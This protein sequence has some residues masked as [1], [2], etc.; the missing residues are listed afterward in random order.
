[1]LTWMERAARSAALDKFRGLGLILVAVCTLSANVATHGGALSPSEHSFH[2]DREMTKVYEGEVPLAKEALDDL[3][4][5]KFESAWEKA[6]SAAREY[7]G[8]WDRALSE[9]VKLKRA[10]EL[11]HR[12][13]DLER[14]ACSLKSRV[15]DHYKELGPRAHEDFEEWSF[16]WLQNSTHEWLHLEADKEFAEIYLWVCR[17]IGAETQASPSEWFPYADLVKELLPSGDEELGD[18]RAVGI[19]AIALDRARERERQ[20]RGDIERDKDIPDFV[21]DYLMALSGANTLHP[22]C[23]AYVRYNWP[24]YVAAA[25]SNWRSASNECVQIWPDL[26]KGLRHRQS[27][28]LQQE[29]SL[30]RGRPSPTPRNGSGTIACPRSLVSRSVSSTGWRMRSRWRRCCGRWRNWTSGVN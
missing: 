4:F 27:L 20:L 19:L 26:G 25:R 1:M 29:S 3:K 16:K 10:I 15:E 24:E 11:L 21:R 22:Y 9:D 2:Y 30:R 7:E 18:D 17:A 28:L 13:E 5:A 8:A 23:D 12:V 6:C 14:K